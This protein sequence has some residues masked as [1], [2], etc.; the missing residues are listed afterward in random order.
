VLLRSTAEYLAAD[1]AALWPPL[2]EAEAEQLARGDVPYFFRLYGRR[3]IHYYA[4]PKLERFETLP[5]AGDV[6]Q[7]EKLLDLSRGLAGKARSK[8][9]TEGLFCVIGA[10]DSP[11]LQGKHA[12]DRISVTFGAR[13]LAVEF[14]GGLRLETQR[15]LSEFV[16][17]VYLPCRC[18][19]VRSVF[20]PARTRC[21][22][23]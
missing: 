2:L 5:L 17:S 1:R 16:S 9:R 20:V 3:G 7:V 13:R 6:P 19:E 18:G 15:D 10:F 11:G 12:G 21:R 4:D 8:L 22:P 14:E 23:R